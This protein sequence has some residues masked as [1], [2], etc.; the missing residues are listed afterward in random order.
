MSIRNKITAIVAAAA[1]AIGGTG[2][3]YSPAYA[4]TS[5]VNTEV[6][7]QT[8]AI[9]AAIQTRIQ[10][11]WSIWVDRQV[12]YVEDMRNNPEPSWPT[13][14][15]VNAAI[16]GHD[17]EGLNFT[18][19]DMPAA[20]NNS[21]TLNVT[22]GSEMG[23]AAS[24]SYIRNYLPMSQVNG[25]IISVPVLRPS[26]ALGLASLSEEMV[27]RDGIYDDGETTFG[28]DVEVSFGDDG[29]IVFDPITGG[30]IENVNKITG[31]DITIDADKVTATGDMDVNGTLT[32]NNA[33]ITNNLTAGSITAGS[34]QINGNLGVSG[35]LIFGDDS[36]IRGDDTITITGTSG[37]TL[38][39]LIVN[40]LESHFQGDVQIDEDLTVD[41]KIYGTA[42]NAEHA[43]NA[44]H[45]DQASNADH[46]SNADYA[47]NAGHSD[48]ADRA[49]S[50]ANADSADTATSFGDESLKIY[51]ANGN[52]INFGGTGRDKTIYFGASSVDG[53]SSPDTF[54]FGGKDGSGI[55]ITNT[56]RANLEGN[57]DTATR[58]Q[59]P[60]TIALAEGA[61]GTPTEFD[62]S[63]NIVIPITN[64]AA[65]YL[66][67]EAN[68]N[69][70]GNA[71][72]ATKF[73]TARKINGVLFDGTGD[74]TVADDTKVAKAGDTMTGL[75]TTQK[76]IQL[77]RESGSQTGISF[78]SADSAAWQNYMAAAQ[79]A[80]QGVLGNL[81]APSGSLVNQMAMRSLVENKA[82]YGWTWENIKAGSVAPQIVAE[83][84][85][86]S[87]NFTTIGD[88]STT[89][90]F[91]GKL[92]GTAAH[93]EKADQ[94]TQADASD[95]ASMVAGYGSTVS[96][97]S[98]SFLPSNRVRFAMANVMP[99]VSFPTN[100]FR[101]VMMMDTYTG[102]D[103]P[104]TTAFAIDKNLATKGAYLLWGTKGSDTWAAVQKILT[105]QNIGGYTAGAASKLETGRTI[106]LS[107][108]ATGTPTLF[109]GTRNISIPVTALDVSK[110]KV[111][112]AGA[113]LPTT[114][115]YSTGIYD[116]TS[117]YA[118]T[119][120]PRTD[121]KPHDLRVASAV[122]ADH[123]DTADT[124]T[125]ALKLGGYDASDYMRKDEVKTIRSSYETLEWDGAG[126]YSWTVPEGVTK[127][128]VTSVGGGGGG[129][130][131]RTTEYNTGL[132]LNIFTGGNG[133][134]VKENV[135]LNVNQGDSV[136]II[137]GAGGASISNAYSY[138]TCNGWY[139]API[140]DWNKYGKAGNNS[141]ISINGIKQ[142]A[143]EARGG[144]PGSI[145]MQTT[146][147]YNT[148]DEVMGYKV[149]PTTTYPG[150]G[151]G[152][153]PMSRITYSYAY[154][155]T[156][157]SGKIGSGGRGTLVTSS[158][159]N[160]NG[161]IVTTIKNP[162]NNQNQE[163][164]IWAGGGGSYGDGLTANDS[165]MTV[166][167]GGGG[168]TLN[169]G[170]GGRSGGRGYVKISYTRL[171]SD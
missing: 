61:T 90:S 55:I 4:V 63:Q 147:S 152:G 9:A 114:G 162:C 95:Y 85:A 156:G 77:G 171:Y 133:G 96:N 93:A 134:E 94:A 168:G 67:G 139:P 169:V 163:Y 161:R 27:R 88:I 32:A 140:S 42:T 11:Y 30:D 73:E 20:R 157:R 165:T 22:V 28:N 166:K 26:F 91:I 75:L 164:Y 136:K 64:L 51:T 149:S 13:V 23:G 158:E 155:A 120:K 128:N 74:I 86:A 83:L 5:T 48:T 24:A 21:F 110:L 34:G 129:S 145:T 15:Q 153:L 137:V 18:E 150:G 112:T 92:V 130:L 143:T 81:L 138:K 160:L 16:G 99:G 60:R 57:A 39:K 65:A 1:I 123:A 141:Y 25:N 41:G 45:A 100:A 167:R 29:S 132:P 82:G 79:S 84:S 3:S 105:D 58:L 131:L 107:G 46:A 53:R 121:G 106:A 122:N 38:S 49:T 17:I 108:A 115:L 170:S 10:V 68:I 56:V 101:D 142:T 69:T 7:N 62:G 111:L 47:T 89:G 135:V 119:L 104:V 159:H 14:A 109:D 50:A 36:A 98:P 43:D 80:N 6:L 126:T 146:L 87:G 40:A 125:N 116:L 118:V 124:A 97:M 54:V 148:A 31:D 72:S 127:I 8:R 2:L 71:G 151:S 144:Q 76:G 113:Y 78:Y 117:K 12:Q 59:T 37:S 44:D 102:S 35:D 66:T 33:H 70:T 52:E 103:I 19:V 154:L